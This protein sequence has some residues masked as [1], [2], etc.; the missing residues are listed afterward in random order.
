MIQVI[1]ISLLLVGCTTTDRVL[2]QWSLLNSEKRH[3]SIR[4]VWVRSPLS[5]PNEGFR[6]INRMTPVLAGDLLITGNA[7]EGIVAYERETGHKK[8]TF[9]VENGVEP[10]ATII[11][12][13]LFVGASDGYFYSLEASTGALQWKFATKAENLS[14]PLLQDGVVY[15]IAGNNVLF[16]LDASSGKQVWLHS[17]Q[18]TS[19]LSVRGGSKP[20]YK[21]GK[22]YAGFSDGSVMA[23][24]ASNGNV[25]WEALLNK[26]KRFRDIDASPVVDGDY[27]YV[28]GYDDKLYC[29]SRNNGD[30]LWKLDGGSYSALTVT[31]D[32]LYYS[33]TEGEVW[34]L[35]KD[36]GNRIWS[37]K[38]KYGIPTQA[39]VFKGSLVFGESQGSLV[40]LDLATGKHIGHFEPGRGILA[41]PLIVEP[42]NRV[43]FI[44]G[45][46]NVY[47]IEAQWNKGVRR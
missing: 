40:F 31:A 44:S 15:F 19:T 42:E 3:F 27:L 16:A 28:G 21:D 33:T 20:S 29:L 46:A 26:N 25:V 10:S 18:D 14:E 41:K 23:F 8:W 47:A 6:K 38:V 17:R 34:A 9:A 11:K 1:L 39:Q 37:H 12:D 24:D 2:D 7:I 22:I 30:L 5:Q 45:E 32:R 43:Y 4:K 36:N 35:Q 13:R